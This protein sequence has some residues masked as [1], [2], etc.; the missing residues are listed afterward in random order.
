MNK[1]WITLLIVSLVLFSVYFLYASFFSASHIAGIINENKEHYSIILSED[2]KVLISIN[3]EV[4]R[5]LASVVKLIVAI[6]FAEQVSARQLDK[7]EQVPIGALERYHIPDTDG[8][9]HEEWLSYLKKNQKLTNDSL[10][11]LWEVARGMIAYSSN[12]NTEYLMD[13]LGID[14]VND[15]LQK[16]GIRTHSK[17]NYLVSDL[18]LTAGEL[19]T[20]TDEEL[21]DKCKLIHEK[22]KTGIISAGS[23]DHEKDLS[24][25][26][27]QLLNNRMSSSTALEYYGLMK[28]IS[29]NTY[30]TNEVQAEL[31][32]IIERQSQP[33]KYD[34]IRYGGKGGSTLWVLN[35][36]VYLERK[37]GKKYEFILFSNYPTEANDNFLI[38]KVMGKLISEITDDTKRAKKLISIINK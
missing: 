36:A 3:P 2:D 17:I 20:N 10:V 21:Y 35:N 9:A 26:K 33:E 38:S 31:N 4:S 24:L 7:T 8:N 25:E 12:A 34:I 1:L 11:A 6:E 27:Q 29:S 18:Y 14:N 5:P 28:K 23:F 22:L 32:S 30:F 16:L 37:N 15:R 13:R 19:E